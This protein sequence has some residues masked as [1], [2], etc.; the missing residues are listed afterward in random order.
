[1]TEDYNV[2]ENNQPNP[3]AADLDG[4]G[5]K[6]ILYSSYDGRV[7]VFW[8]D[9]TE[10]H[11]WPY[12]VYDSG[13]GIFR[14]ASEPVVADLDNDGYAE[15]LFSSWVQKGSALTGKL[16]ILDYQGSVIHEIDLPVAYGSPDWNGGL[17]APTLDNV[18][19]DADLEVVINTAHSGVVC[20]DLPDTADARILWR[21]GRGN[22]QRSGVAVNRGDLNGDTCVTA[23]DITILENFLTANISPG[24]DQFRMPLIA[25][26]LNGDGQVRSI[27]LLLLADFL[28]GN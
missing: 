5:Y 7:H 8:L 6:E 12:S 9:K 2:I 11:N 10:H 15:V 25:A 13:E 19:D 1:L 3:V 24:D 18:D 17:P 14:F 16:H 23:L 20:Y 21:T 28:V 4:D 26:D 27:D 22:Y